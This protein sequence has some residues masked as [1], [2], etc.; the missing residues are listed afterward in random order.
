MADDLKILISAGLNT[1]KSIGEINTS[2]KG[3]EKRINKLKLNI[4]INDKVFQTLN[5][6]SKQMQQI[7]NVAKNTG[8]IIEESIMP[9][10]SRIKRTYFNGLKSEFSQVTTEAKRAGDIERKTLSELEQGYAKL[11]SQ[12]RNYADGSLKSITSTYQNTSGNGRVITT[13]A[14]GNV[15]NYKD[16]E[17]IKKFSQEQD[18]LRAKLIELATTGR[19]ASDELRK[20]GTSIYSASTLQQLN[21]LKNRMSNMKFNTSLV[22][23]QEKV[24]QSLKKMYDQG[25]VNESFFRNFNKV[26]NSSKNVAEIEKLQAA[27]KRV[28]DVS[29]NQNL[30][31]SLLNQAQSMLGS[32][33]RTLDRTG[34]SNLVND[35]NNLNPTTTNA[36]RRLQ[37]MR[38]QLNGFSESTVTAHRH[39]MS[40]TDS[41]KMAFTMMPGFMLANAIMTAPIMALKDMSSRLIEIDTQ[42][43]EIKRVMNEPDFKFV[44][45]LQTAVDTSDRLSSKLTDVLNIMGSFGRMGFS[46]SQLTD[47]T[48]TAQV[49]Q[50]IS[51]LDAN[52]SVDT[53][54]SAMLNFNIAGQDSISIADKLN[55]VK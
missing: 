52:G 2:I 22:A 10:G 28:N 14:T 36:S 51:D 15:I 3:I 45:M 44:D 41:L 50:N 18:K 17:N 53:L 13:N 8:K 26:I 39:L 6:F 40:F 35:L 29:K 25:I 32:N 30:Q 33:S 11:N 5:N 49:F 34:I 54:V 12:V 38:N 55:E 23:E 4:E 42:M 7:G 20:I 37:E 9:D 16:I 19:Y 1:G 21:N 47:I 46:D 27:L 24:T 43:T 48:K 31:Q